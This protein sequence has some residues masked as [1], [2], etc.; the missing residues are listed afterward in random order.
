MTLLTLVGN[1]EITCR[2]IAYNLP[3]YA[4]TPPI[5][6]L[7]DRFKGYPGVVVSGGPSLRKNIDLLGEVKGKGVLCAV[8]SLFKPLAQRGIMPDFVTSLDFHSI[9]KQFF[10]G[11]EDFGDVHMIAEPK[12]SWHVLNST[13]GQ[14]R[15]C[16]AISR[17][18]SLVRSWRVAMG[19]R[20]VR[21][22]R[23]WRSICCS[24]LAVIRS[25]LSA[26]PGVFGSLLLRAGG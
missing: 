26:G 7:R 3:T 25:C 12:V 19:C 8:Q 24:T 15:C 2:N 4:S 23:T 5:D 18:S 6:V 11:I 21:P 16:T 1:S 10:H 20:L 13:R 17:R 22:S 14:S 9:S